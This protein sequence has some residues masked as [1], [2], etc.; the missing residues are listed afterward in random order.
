MKFSI[1][2]R[3]RLSAFFS[4]GFMLYLC[5]MLPFSVHGATLAEYKVKAAFILKFAAFVEWPADVLNPGT[6]PFKICVVGDDPFGDLLPQEIPADG[7]D[8]ISFKVARAS[9]H[10]EDFSKVHIMFISN[11]DPDAVSSIVRSIK[12]KPVL[13][14]GEGEDFLK[15]G[16]IIAFTIENQRVRFMVSLKG[17]VKAHLKISSQLL[18]LASFVLR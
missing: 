8:G 18:S 16:G 7:P 5:M 4:I 10:D 6:S 13:T 3:S 12:E 15:Q 1:K 17:A 9:I 14:I 11:S 2:K